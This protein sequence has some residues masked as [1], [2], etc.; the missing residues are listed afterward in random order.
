MNSQ[1]SRSLEQLREIYDDWNLPLRRRIDAAALCLQYEGAA[2]DAFEWLQSVGAEPEA[3]VSLRIIALKHA[4]EYEQR[5]VQPPP[6]LSRPA[7]GA[8][9]GAR[10]DEAGKRPKLALVKDGEEAG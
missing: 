4:A 3:P 6:P 8:G 7:R 10:F 2:S 5:R 9:I 1:P